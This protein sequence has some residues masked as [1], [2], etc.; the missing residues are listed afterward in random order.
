[1]IMAAVGRVVRVPREAD[2][3][4]VTAVSGSGP[5]YLYLLIDMLIQTARTLG[6]DEQAAATLAL[7]TACG[8]AALAAASDESMQELI[9]RVRSPGGTTAAALDSLEEQNIRGIFANALTAARDRAVALADEA[10]KQD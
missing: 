9:A 8:A 4:A 10:H 6:L 3:D 1:R 7:E 5:A 2:I